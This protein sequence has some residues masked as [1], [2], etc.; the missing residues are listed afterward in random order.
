M[1]S[2]LNELDGLD[3]GLPSNLLPD[4]WDSELAG[5]IM[6]I[7]TGH[8]GGAVEF[9][10]EH[11]EEELSEDFNFDGIT[12]TTDEELQSGPEIGSETDDGMHELRQKH[13]Y[14]TTQ[15]APAKRALPVKSIGKGKAAPKPASSECYNPDTCGKSHSLYSTCM[16]ILTCFVFTSLQDP[17]HAIQ[18]LHGSK[19]SDIPFQISS[20]VN[21]DQL[22]MV[23][24]EKLGRF[25]DHVK[26]QYRLDCKAK[27]AFTSLQS[28][29]ELD[30]FIETMRSLII[31]PRL[32][33]GKASTRPMK[34]V[35]VYF[36][37]VAS[38]DDSMAPESTG[39]C[40]KA[41]C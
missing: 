41:V 36:D 14:T 37:D 40:S 1:I 15:C 30:V 22:H 32:A 5:E 2:E 33:N 25:P 9:E 23:V 7:V 39:N 29:E 31:P 13:L 17:V 6:S 24:S 3:S 19:L 34:A 16:Y 28:D 26:L 11:E 27:T 18:R 35:T 12:A 20:T 8:S 38:D 10:E 4:Y 21:H